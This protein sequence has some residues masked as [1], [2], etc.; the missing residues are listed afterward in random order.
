VD[1]EKTR[2]APQETPLPDNQAAAK[3]PDEASLSKTDD[4]ADWKRLAYAAILTLAASGEIFSVDDVFALAGNPPRPYLISAVFPTAVK[5]GV[6]VRAG[7]C[8]ARD[9]RARLAWRGAR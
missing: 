7:A 6:I 1:A 8:V 9:G 4:T 2:A 3:P 5:R